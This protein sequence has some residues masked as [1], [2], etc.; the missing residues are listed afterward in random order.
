MTAWLAELYVDDEV[1]VG[2][3]V[4]PRLSEPIA[5]VM[6]RVE[7]PW[8]GWLIGDRG[9]WAKKPIYPRDRYYGD[10]RRQAPP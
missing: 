10:R 3:Q 1:W 8:W 2:K 7:A 4:F 5:W 6:W 9:H